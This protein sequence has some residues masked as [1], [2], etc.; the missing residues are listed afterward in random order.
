LLAKVKAGQMSCHAA[1]VE[2][3]I[4]KVPSAWGVAWE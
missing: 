4:V 2:A 1:A 3:G